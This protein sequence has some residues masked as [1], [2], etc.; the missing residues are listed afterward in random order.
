[1]EERLGG[2]GEEMGNLLTRD[3]LE[4]T[5]EGSEGVRKVFE[6]IKKEKRVDFTAIQTVGSKGW[7]G[8]A[9]GIVV[10]A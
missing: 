4:E 3:S 10:A 5:D 9:L 7:D 8:F 6:S 2:D 1:V